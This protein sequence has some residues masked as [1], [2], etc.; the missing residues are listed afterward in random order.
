MDLIVKNAHDF[1]QGHSSVHTQS[2]METG[3]A[4]SDETLL[5][6][7]ASPGAWLFFRVDLLV[8]MWDCLMVCG[9]VTLISSGWGEK[10]G[11]PFLFFHRWLFFFFLEHSICL[12][13]LEYP[14]LKI[15]MIF[16]LSLISSFLS[17]FLFW[18]LFA[19]SSSLYYTFPPLSTFSILPTFFHSVLLGSGNV[20]SFTIRGGLLGWRAS[21]LSFS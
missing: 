15:W 3:C 6:C 7:N 21:W 9:H 17:L 10:A 4:S 11:I 2:T 8:M 1:L 12:C 20:F 19:H 14:E 16:F 5:K 18:L 13:S